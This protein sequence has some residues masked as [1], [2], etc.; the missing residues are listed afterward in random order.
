[1]SFRYRILL[2]LFLATFSIIKLRSLLKKKENQTQPQE[3]QNPQEEEK[4]LNPPKFS[5]TSGFYPEDFSIKLTSEENTKIFYTVDSSDPKT[6]NTSKEYKD[7]ILIYDR[8]SEPNIYSAISGDDDSPIS[9]CR[10]QPY[11]HPPAY[12]V[13]KAMV[14]RAVVKN[15]KGEYSKVVS[16]TFFVTNKNLTKYK[17]ITV[18]SL[19]TDPDNLFSPDY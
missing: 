11:Y 5:H 18:I 14:V 7:D 16:E 17:N 19:V 4:I 13:K 8:S 15:E 9:I 10:F 2:F 3:P 12:P 1:M 6:S